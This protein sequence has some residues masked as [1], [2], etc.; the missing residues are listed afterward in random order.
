MML[1]PR[2]VRLPECLWINRILGIDMAWIAAGD[3]SGDF[4]F[5]FGQCRAGERV[6][7]PGLQIAAGCRARGARDQVA[8]QNGVHRFVQKPAAGNAGIDG[9]EHIHG[10]GFLG[11]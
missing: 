10:G 11:G 2:L 6:D 7:L 4:A 8:N 5:K 9:F 1:A 3:R